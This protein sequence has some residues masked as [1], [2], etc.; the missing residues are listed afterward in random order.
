METQE[1]PPIQVLL[2]DDH[3]VVRDALA[4]M[5]VEEHDLEVQHCG[6]VADALKYISDGPIDVVILDYDL[7]TSRAPDLLIKLK[8]IRFQ[9]VVLILSAYVNDMAVRQLLGNGVMGVMSKNGPAANLK[10]A[11]HHVYAGGMWIDAQFRTAADT[12]E[13]DTVGFTTRE[14]S[15]LLDVVDGLSNKE[16][17]SKYGITESGA[18]AVLQRLFRKTGANTRSQLVRLAIEKGFDLHRPASPNSTQ[19]TN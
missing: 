8:D 6:T 2:V 1:V 4:R 11:I 18:K 12:E 3:E 15:T 10:A 19:N 5:L 14:W 16:I 9:G 13:D 7:G 17:A